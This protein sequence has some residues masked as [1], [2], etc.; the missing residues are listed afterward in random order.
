MT[1]AIERW[2]HEAE[3]HALRAERVDMMPATV[4]FIKDARIHADIAKLSDN[5]ESVVHNAQSAESNADWAEEATNR[6]VIRG[7]YEFD[8]TVARTES[9]GVI[10]TLE[11]FDVSHTSHD[12][13]EQDA[14]D[15]LKENIENS[16][17]VGMETLSLHTPE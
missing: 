7:N 5:Y 13:N 2:K 4:M 11:G 10:A 3:R 17:S 9:G 6:R 14:L 12:G 1:K 15:G 8:A 16:N